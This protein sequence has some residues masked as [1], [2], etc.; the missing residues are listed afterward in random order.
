MLQ[1]IPY[2]DTIT[3]ANLAEQCGCPRAA[4]AV[5]NAMR[6]NSVPIVVPCHRVLKSDGGIG[7]WSGKPGWKERLLA[8]ESGNAFSYKDDSK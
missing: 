3:Y 4:R 6:K 7:G 8:M 2:G 1:A 5:G